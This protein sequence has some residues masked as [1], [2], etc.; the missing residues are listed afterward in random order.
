MCSKI[1]SITKLLLKSKSIMEQYT[2]VQNERLNSGLLYNVFYEIGVS[3]WELQHSAFISSLLNPKGTHGASD[4]FIKDF[5]TVLKKYNSKLENILNLNEIDYKTIIVQKEKNIG[6]KTIDSG[7]KIDIFIEVK[8]IKNSS[9]K[10]AIAIE[11]KIFA[12]DQESQLF[13]Y[14]NFLNKHYKDKNILLYLTLNGKLPS[15]KSKKELS[16]D[17][18]LCVSY[19]CFICD[20]LSLCI[21]ESAT[22]P[23]IRETLIQYVNL[24]KKLTFKDISQMENNDFIKLLL[25]EDNLSIA[26][27]LQASIPDA[28]EAFFDQYL[29]KWI[30]DIADDKNLEYRKTLDE[31]HYRNYGPFCMLSSTK[32]PYM[33]YFDIKVGFQKNNYENMYIQAELKPEVR[34]NN[35]IIPLM[36]K[37]KAKQKDI[38]WKDVKEYCYGFFLENGF[39][40]WN[41]KDISNSINDKGIT[42]KE[43]L[44][45]KLEI[46]INQINL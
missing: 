29:C 28:K 16:D 21:K 24:I 9:R 39:R 8:S 37:M 40:N 46:I 3:K 27:L 10:F 1:D 17:D 15:N 6:L 44:K 11:N 2:S 34:N 32:E 26:E 41:S 19:R 14:K 30:N 31:E 35:I 42:F 45:N 43:E 7:G 12:E 25:E 20:W 33:N 38:I 5:F 13:R 18:F 36:V 23:L 4:K 22:L